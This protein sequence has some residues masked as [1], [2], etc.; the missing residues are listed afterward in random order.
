[1]EA[2]ETRE[3]GEGEGEMAMINQIAAKWAGS[4]HADAASVAFNH[5][6]EEDPAEVPVACAKCHSSSGYQDFI[7]NDGSAVGK[8]D[9]P[10]KI[11]DPIT[12]ATCHN[13]AAD[14]LTSVT[15]PNGKELT[16]LDK[17]AICM[18]C[19]SGMGSSKS[20]DDA[21]AK[22]AVG[23]DDVIEGQAL[24]G[25][26]YLAD[27]SVQAG[28]DGG[29][30]YQYAG[31]SYVGTFK[32]ADPVNSCTECHDPHSLHTKEVEGSDANL[33]STCH[34]DVQSYQDYKK[35]SMSKV[36]YDGDGT[37]ESTYDEIEG[38]RQVLI[39]A[40]Q[41]Y[42]TAKSGMGFIYEPAVYPYAF[43]DTNGDG[44]VS[45]GEAAFPNQFK[46]FTPRMLKA[47]YN[48]MFVT[49]EPS[50]YVHNPEYVLQLMYDSIDDLSQFS[51]VT[52]EGLVRP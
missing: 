49:K 45:E 47:A 9:Q 23:D 10:G 20:V 25:D 12:C 29:M 16:D 8:V 7:G 5:W 41:G 39:K 22:A 44:A 17:S 40:L 48:L 37:T 4:A 26:H 50:A 38:T 15:L 11:V 31:K 43:V 46:A 52:T 42:A 21:I 33:C 13:D 24:L 34:S 18:T 6:N 2:V 32:H 19:H 35:I 36:D 27:A 14:K 1:M 30:G 28:A 3:A 51:G